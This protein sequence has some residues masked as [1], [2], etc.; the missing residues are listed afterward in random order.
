M[1]NLLA[2][3]RIITSSKKWNLQS[4]VMYELPSVMSKRATSIGFGKKVDLVPKNRSPSPNL[5][6]KKSDFEP[7]ASK[8]V[9]FGLGRE[10]VKA[11]SIFLQTNF[12]GPGEYNNA[13]K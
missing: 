9:S 1:G 8:G 13:Q 6:D 2:P 10:K 3:L 4:D 5:Y 12:P 11:V 7:S